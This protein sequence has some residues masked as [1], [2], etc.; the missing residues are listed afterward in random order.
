[1]QACVDLIESRCCHERRDSRFWVCVVDGSTFITACRN[2]QTSKIMSDVPIGQ[3]WGR[4]P[5]V[6]LQ[7]KIIGKSK[8]DKKKK[9]I[10]EIKM[11]LN[12][13]REEK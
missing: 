7:C 6:S 12:R 10:K 5:V 11:K 1:M 4:S 2:G 9:K 3:M 13:I 8:K